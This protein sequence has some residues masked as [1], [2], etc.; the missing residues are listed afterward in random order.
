VTQTLAKSPVLPRLLDGL[1]D[2]PLVTLERHR[3]VHGPLPSR[4]ELDGA[5]LVELIAASDLRGRGGAAFPVARKVRAVL[6]A[7]GRPIVLANGSESEPL[8]GKD[9]LL[10][11]ELP[12]LVL[13]GAALAARAVGARHVVIA[14]KASAPERALVERAI[15]ERA[16]QHLDE[17]TFEVFG[18]AET[19]IA[20]QET[21]LVA[22]INRGKALPTFQPPRVSD[23]GIDRRPTLVQ[24]VETLA[25][26]ALIARQGSDWYRAI[27]VPGEPGSTLVTIV[28]AG[29]ARTVYEI[30]Y[31]TRLGD[32]LGAAG[33]DAAS[34]G[35]LLVGGYFGTWLPAELAGDLR[36]THEALARYDAS[37]G[38]GVIAALPRE[39]CPVAETVRVSSY[40]AAQSAGQ[41][42]PCV[43]GSSAIARRLEAARRGSAGQLAFEDVRRW[44]LE[45]QDRGACHHPTGLGRFVASAL[46]T[47]RVEFEDHARRGPCAACTAKAVLM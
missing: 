26:I 10:L 44:T 43:H 33:V 42:G 18:C 24:N 28:R 14:V 1:G 38:C 12:H 3:E 9:A 46:R 45:I 36:L 37:L 25:H 6:A 40:L 27:G 35:G 8:S 39:A 22:Q 17:V 34:L 2:G 20:G 13:D 29:G 15:D 23:R 11:R 32:L 47:F 4:R 31:G 30:A 5:E 19:F 41:C 16:A 7:R 21:A